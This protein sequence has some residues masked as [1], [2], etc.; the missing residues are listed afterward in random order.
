MKINTARVLFLGLLVFLGFD[1]KAAMAE[2]FPLS[3]KGWQ[4]TVVQIEG[5]NSSKALAVG[6]VKRNNAEEYCERDP[7]GITQQYGGKL[8]KGQCVQQVMAKE[9]GKRY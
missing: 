4:A 2:E 5:V 6:E 1:G 9:Q 8:T 7:G 3:S